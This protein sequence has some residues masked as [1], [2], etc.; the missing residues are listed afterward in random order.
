MTRTQY[1]NP[2]PPHAVRVLIRV[3][4]HHPCGAM[5]RITMLGP[6]TPFVRDP[7]DQSY[8]C[9]H[10]YGLRHAVSAEPNRAGELHD[11]RGRA[12]VRPPARADLADAPGAR[13]GTLQ[14]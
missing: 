11:L 12:P 3:P 6:Q 14:S 13:G 7:E 10:L 5:L 1:H 9:P 8:G 2:S 4:A